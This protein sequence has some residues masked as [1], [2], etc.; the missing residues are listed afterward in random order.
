M[1]KASI[2]E[3]S[4]PFCDKKGLPILPVRYAI[5]RTDRG[6]APGLPP[7]FG[8]GVAAI[9]LPDT[10]RYTLR[11]LRSGF[12]YTFDERRKEW[13]SYV[14]NDQ[15]YLY[16]FDA[17]AKAPPLVGDK[18]FSEACRIKADPYKA[19]CFTVKDAA[20]ATK[21]WM[22]FS[23]VAWTPD[24]L[25]E[26]TAAILGRSTRSDADERRKSLQC[27]DVAAWR[28]GKG[29]PH[30]ATFDELKH[31]AE[32]VADGAALQRDTHEYIKH[33]LPPPYTDPDDL[34]RTDETSSKAADL[35]SPMVQDLLSSGVD[36]ARTEGRID[37]AAWKFSVQPLWLTSKETPSLIAWGKEQAGQ[38]R[39]AMFGV[40]DPAG[41]AAD[42]N[43]LAIQ[44]G[45][46]FTDSRDRRWKFETAKLIG[47]L[48]QAIGNGAVEARKTSAGFLY[49]SL[50]EPSFDNPGAAFMPTSM[51]KRQEEL[52]AELERDALR[53]IDSRAGQIAEEAWASDYETRLKADKASGL[54]WKSYQTVYQLDL[55]VFSNNILM[56]LDR[57]FVDWLGHPSLARVFKFHYDT[58]DL[59]SGESYLELVHSLIAEA[60]G[61]Q[62]AAAWLFE[63]IERDPTESDAWLVRS[64]VMNQ[65]PLTLAW[66]Q[67]AIDSAAQSAASWAVAAEKFHEQLRNYL[68]SGRTAG[69]DDSY[70]G[71]LDSL[72]YQVAGPMVQ[73]LSAEIDKGL[74]ASLP[75]R[76]RM[77][78]LVSVAKARNPDLM[79]V[80]LR[81]EM[82]RQQRIRMV[83]ALL[84][85][86]GG[87]NENRYRSGVRAVLDLAAESQGVRRPIHAV[88]LIDKAMAEELLTGQKGSAL[89]V[90]ISQVVTHSQFDAAVQA[91]IGKVFDLEVKAGVVQMIL[92]AVTLRLAYGEMSQA[93]ADE[94]NH[95][96][97]NFAG[98]VV[99]LVGL[100]SAVVGKALEQTA[101]GASPLSR[102]F[103]FLGVDFRS[104]SGWF[105]GI[106]R[107]LGALGGAIG[108]ALVVREGAEWFSGNHRVIGGTLIVAG[109]VSVAISILAIASAAG[110]PIGI[111]VGL[112]ICVVM[113][114]VAWLT[115][116]KIQAWLEQSLYFGK[117]P[118]KFFDGPF[119]QMSALN[120][121]SIGA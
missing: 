80:D 40:L 4:C 71:K 74:A 99:A 98:G 34:R 65:E 110:G 106:G 88:L 116:N 108:G 118:R 73:R 27:M 87:G 102:P 67:N 56:P 75:T 112:V 31:V 17:Y 85:S 30:M 111:T 19:R 58:K 22:G 115:P 35:L 63:Q 11:L 41:L 95:K 60:G 96:V 10:A 12:L 37:C 26:Y 9:T 113:I 55:E 101:W 97:A 86:I 45:I 7:G 36:K 92:S 33:F 24:V 54:Q 68:T 119:S 32:F 70:F 39:P 46:E 38:L 3:S 72:L 29:V 121:L 16:E 43:G 1:T 82:T 28:G 77:S 5:A 69:A 48:K 15:G 91:G 89:K 94:K 2:D 120:E 109:V 103:S 18:T 61:R 57:A 25:E 81:S 8:E 76:M 14:V 84:A 93:S 23:D 59:R 104:R 52:A 20:T 100:M 66:K 51:R 13:R 53:R 50:M 21:V 62:K 6:N 78:L 90:G 79:V 105:V 83:S 64:F 42:L 114:V 117:G 47:A 44:R 107:L 49:R